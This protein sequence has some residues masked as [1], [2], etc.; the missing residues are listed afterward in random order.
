MNKA[1]A[2]DLKVIAWLWPE[3]WSWDGTAWQIGDQARSF[4]QTVAGHPA[5][6][7]VYG[8][9]EPY[10]QGCWGCGYTTREQQL[11]S[12]AIKSIAEVPIY[13]EIGSAA[14]WT[15]QGEE[16]AFADG[17][18]DYCGIWYYPFREGKYERERLQERLRDDVALIRE[19]AP[20]SQIIWGLQSFA[21]D[22]PGFYM[23]S[24]KEM[25]DLAAVVL[26]AGVDGA[27]WYPWTFGELYDDFLY[28]HPELY[29]VVRQVYD[30]V[31]VP[32]Q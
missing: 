23:P 6:F 5:L 21:Q 31:V 32:I 20:K 4:V 30:T 22:P 27:S 7:A 2:H 19:R 12:D 26:L 8:L 14:F 9:H 17:V 13:S 18:C 28:N 1:D 29:D 25:Y 10:W 11:L 15:T 24:V 3:G 16:T